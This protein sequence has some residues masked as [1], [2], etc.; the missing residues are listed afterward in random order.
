MYSSQYSAVG[1]VAMAVCMRGLAILFGVLSI[2]W[3]QG[4]AMMIPVN[5]QSGNDS[6]CWTAQDLQENNF[7]AY[8]AG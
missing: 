1:V 4:K 6:E 3:S 7:T 2:C 5:S 8:P